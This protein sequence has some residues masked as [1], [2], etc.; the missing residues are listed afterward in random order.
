MLTKV[1]SEQAGLESVSSLRLGCF[2]TNELEEVIP[3][4]ISKIPYTV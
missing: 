1:G 2:W 4:I 3:T